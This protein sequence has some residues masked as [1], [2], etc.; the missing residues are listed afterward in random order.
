VSLID[1]HRQW[2]KA[3]AGLGQ[4]EVARQDSFCRYVVD[5]DQPVIVQDA[6]RDDR[7]S[8]H[9]AVTG[10]TH[11]RFYAGV[12]LKT[13]D[14]H[15]IGTV[16]AIDRETRS[17]SHRD[18]TILEELAGAA[19]D[20]IELLQSVSTDSLTDAL[21]RRAFRHEAEQLI[22]ASLRH[23][24]SL[25]CIVFDIDKFKLVNDTFGHATG[26][27]VLKAVTATCR[28]AL[29]AEDLFGR[30]GGE[31]FAI[32]L[33]HIDRDG[34]VAAAEKIRTLIASTP[35]IGD[36]GSLNVTVS[37]GVSALSIV[38][39]D[40][41]TV[42]AQA[43][44]AM[45]HAKNNGRNRCVSWSSMPAPDTTGSRR[46]VLKAGSILFNNR[47]STVDCTV[48]SLGSDS[49]AL[50]VSNSA[51]IPDEFVLLIKGDGYETNCRVIAQDRQNIEVSFT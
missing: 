17:F 2:Y 26:D 36:F 39:K 14:G 3:C 16:C 51:G 11:I 22:S 5:A 20:R 49:A 30:L 8:S 21:T 37:L 38:C 47:R 25:S 7:F 4:D 50:S 13:R 45:Y 24:H 44:A 35:I 34:A 1:A 48:K 23:Q 40:I 28:A 29:R 10:S 18:V 9:P 41:D 15:T 32:L 19:M 12:P 33:P 43:D 42:L 31:E 46:R 6:T 27:E